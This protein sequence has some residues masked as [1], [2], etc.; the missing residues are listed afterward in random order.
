[1]QW[2]AALCVKRPVF[3]S[4]L[5]L[6]L[7]VI[8]AFS[9]T[10][11]GVDRFPK[12]DLPTVIVTTV[13]A[14]AAPEQIET[15][16][17]DKIEEGVN[18]ISGIDEL[19]SVSSEGIS[20]VMISFLLDKDT[21][22]AAQEVRDKVNGVL[23]LLPK[24][25]QQPRV[26]RFD[27]DSAP[28][29]SLALSA[30][31][32]VR[33]IT[34]FADKVLRRQLESV[35]GVGQVLVLGGRS[36]QINI[37][38]DGDRLRAYNIT[39]NEVARA[40]QAQNIEIP[41]GRVDQGPQ[42]VTLRTRGRVQAVT[43]FN[44]IVI[45]EK[46]G[47]PVRI[48]DVAR[49]ED[50]E[51]EPETL[52]NVS[53]EDTVL[54]Q[55][56]RQ[57]GTNT[58]EVVKAV[59]ERLED[60]K[61]L[62]PAGYNVRL[63]RDTSN[64]IEASIHNVEEH[65]IVGSI[66]AALVVL[67]FLANLRST[68]I[69][70][71]AIPTSIIATFGLIW[72]M[73]FT[74]NLMTMLALTL[75]VGIVIDDAIVVLENIYR[76][77]EEKHD[78]QFHAAI[79]ATQEIGLAV[80]ATTLS[81][82]AIFVPVGFM[83]GIVGRFMKSF[84]LTMAFA[85]MVS[86]LVSFTLTPMLSARWL[87]VDRNDDGAGDPP[88]P[89]QKAGGHSS[90]DSRIFHAIDV[91]Y[92]R[93]LE[94]SM[95]HRGVVAGA[96]VLVL[97]SSAPLF[98]A[99]NKNFMP[100]DDQS[101]FEI[102][103]RAPE[104][105]SLE[106]TDVITNR[107]ANAVR[108]RFPE[109]VDYTLVTIA[110]DPAK[111][112]NLGNI[113]VRLKPIEHRSSDQ[114]VVMDRIRKEVLPPLAKDLRTSVQP[115]AAI[116]GSGAQ[117]ADVQFVIN[118][119][120][121]RK[122]EA[123]SK[124]LVARVKTL[125]G[126]VD[127]D[128]SLNVGKPELSVQVDRPKAADLG[129]QI[130]DAAEALRLLV[131]GDQVTNYNEGG[132]QYEVHLRAR[133]ENRTTEQAISGLTVPSSRLGSVSLDNVADFTPGTAPSDINRLARQRQ[134]TVFCGLLPTASQAAVQTTILEEFNAV[135]TS[136]EYIGRFS[137][138]SREL[139]RAAQNFLLAFFLSLVFMYLILAAQFESW[140]HPITI[141]LSLPLT[142]P[143]ALLSILIFRQ[144][145]NIFSALGLLVLFGV[146]KKNSIL[147][148]DHANQ[149]KD[150]G[151]ST[152]DAVVQASRDRLRPILMTT[153]AFVAGMIPLIVS[154]GIGSGTNHAI[155]FVIFGG[156][157][158]ALLLTLLV[159]PVAYSLFDD[160]S[161]IR[162]FGRR[163]AA[164]AIETDEKPESFGTA[165]PSGAAMRRTS[166]IVLL[167]AGLAATASAQTTQTTRTTPATL[168]L[169]VDEAVKMAL[170]HNI[171]L[172]V[173]RLDPQISDTRV[174]AAAGAFKPTFN[175]SAQRNSQVQPPASF[176]FPV[177][178]TS[179]INTTNAGLAQRLPWFGTTYN[180]GWT[181]THTNSNSFLNSYN[182]LLQS[183]LSLNVSQPLVRD[184][185]ID[186]ARLNLTTSR[187]NR[188]IA[189]TRLR[190]SV[191]HTT[192]QA[193]SA[194][195]GL[196][197]AKALVEARQSA[198]TL[199]Q[200]LVRV[201]KAKVDVGT[202]PPLDLVSAQ[203]E[204]AA[205]QEQ[206]IIAETTVKQVEDRLRLLIFD[207]TQR[208]TWNVKIE[209]VDS[210]PAGMPAIDVDGAVTRALSER[211]DLLRARKEIDNSQVTVK[212]TSSQKL[213]D[214]RL[215]A[216]YQANG[217]GGTQVLRS[218]G[219][220]G[221]IIGSGAETGFGSVLNQIFANDFPTWAVGVSISYPI[222]QSTEEANAA[223]A[224]LERSQAQERLKSAQAR[225]IQQVRDAAWQIDMNAKRIDTTR[226]A[227]ELAE[228]RL[229]AERKRLEVGMSTSFLVIQAQRDL[230][231]AKQNELGAVLAYDLALVDFEALQEAGPAAS[232]SASSGVS[233]PAAI[234]LPG[235][236]AV[237]P[238]TAA[239][240]AVSRATAVPGVP[241]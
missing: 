155:G 165:V 8:G 195:W 226:A 100:Q 159:T 122:L 37:W 177:A 75:S 9:F 71:I 203:A 32:P 140:L 39:V 223:R 7:T 208:E 170:D 85:I 89:G 10:R 43:E 229:D 230:A 234:S 117:A 130:G 49:V 113:Y 79:E 64:F 131:G 192:A 81:L 151:M 217:L 13:Q 139:G 58:V 191:V 17:T 11:L 48:G 173:D 3:A 25:I 61:P 187:T 162:L 236:T 171:D 149:L 215:N 167:A 132:E 240:A 185:S 233:A 107:I 6:S 164:T 128:T 2:L 228:Q 90:K 66:L 68:I 144:S 31:K 104:G 179:D 65:L 45:R 111:T 52:A 158:L 239:A 62:L 56:R 120:D 133:A 186:A 92:T 214:I 94:W 95:R 183:G 184:L 108:Q 29:L 119:P 157:S 12:V 116:G 129:V 70:A 198:L 125:P 209:P 138:R 189:D 53:G 213:P 204:V 136:N 105:T 103:L 163:R 5:I 99:V 33:D 241:Q 40:L 50:G 156:Q 19:R 16:I 24:T 225:A 110:G 211:A 88:A 146:V 21:D 199:A 27:P 126:V 121:L 96:A 15:E 1:M 23:P 18:T 59:K 219:F 168:G 4:V 91:F 72:Y 166:L 188:D 210:P 143:F 36:R 196:V 206:L 161:K 220:P 74:L 148:I 194:Y 221:T 207:T 93:L 150:A 235:S 224:K 26:D 30:N 106:Q 47:H 182:P 112:R 109:A 135:K 80:L 55:V 78:D 202:S 152:H 84:G 51:A 76:F 98:M 174:A 44:D 22:V 101:E 73:G 172:N 67:L 227:R 205:N 181:A 114:F 142:L 63:V 153:F 77:I 216:S 102:N 137:G 83:G 190:E 180:V 28:V 69:S 231:Q 154:R 82:V 134:V 193:K 87:K 169:T 127:V 41:G 57:S 197:A 178:T 200:E 38:L 42:S 115:V 14:G 118:G 46:D 201:N 86:L 147:Q 20:Q 160:A 222:G 60:V 218:G 35:D 175:T 145:L 141:L 54:L 124:Q 212:Y 237:S 238:A 34:E 123:I 232:V 176:L 97:L